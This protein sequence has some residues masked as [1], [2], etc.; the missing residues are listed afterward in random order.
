[1]SDP[2]DADK[3]QPP[4]ILNDKIDELD[5]LIN[6]KPAIEAGQKAPLNIPV[7]D[8][9]V[10]YNAESV[11]RNVLSEQT[12]EMKQPVN[13]EHI[14]QEQ[15]SAVLDQIEAKIA[16]ELDSLVDIL[17]NT[18]KDNLMSEIKTQLINKPPGQTD[19]DIGTAES[20][21]DDPGL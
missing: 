21:K 10:D 11:L 7:L 19:P 8:E 2:S 16:D 14:P 12:T 20:D 6:S 5:D 15:L 9:I 13:P 4:S 17:K 18:I 3:N 1:M